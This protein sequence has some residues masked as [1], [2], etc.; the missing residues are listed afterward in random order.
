MLHGPSTR[1]GGK[2]SRKL[3]RSDLTGK[4]VKALGAFPT[5]FYGTTRMAEVTVSGT[6]RTFFVADPTTLDIPRY[7]KDGRLLSVLH[8][9]EK[10]E[11]MTGKDL[12]PDFSP[13]DTPGVTPPPMPTLTQVTV[14]PF[15]RRVLTDDVGRWWVQDYPRDYVTA[16]AVWTAIDSTGKLLGR[17]T[18]P[19]PKGAADISVS[20]FTAN[21]V[22]VKR[23]DADGAVHFT[24]YHLTLKPGP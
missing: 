15:Y 17:L 5:T 8:L 3:S 12:L 11:A 10:A 4:V 16:P 18:I 9:N 14:W 2:S 22:F 23:R 7:D 20:A 19:K 6:R 21:G 1:S 13:R 24:L